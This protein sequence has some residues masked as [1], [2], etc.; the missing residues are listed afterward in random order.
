MIRNIL[1]L[2]LLLVISLKIT[3]QGIE[4]FEGTWDQVLQKAKAENKPIFVDAY[5]KWCG[6]CKAMSKTVFPDQEVGKFF[7]KNFISVK[8]DMEEDMG[9]AF[10]KV[11]PV[12][13][14]P[15]L[16]FI[17]QDGKLLKRIVGARKAD[18]LIQEGKMVLLANDRSKNF[19]ADYAA[20][21]R[22]YDFMLQYVKA[23]ASSGKSATKVANEY[24]AS[25]PKISKEQ[26]LRFLFEAS[27]DADSKIFEEMV[28]QKNEILKM[29]ST[30]EFDERVIKS[31]ENT[32]SKA[33]EFET[34]SL[35]NEAIGKA[36]N[37]SNN[38]LVTVFEYQSKVKYFGALKYKDKFNEALKNHIKKTNKK[39]IAALKSIVEDANNY[40]PADPLI[41]KTIADVTKT[42]YNNDKSLENLFLYCNTLSKAGDL[43]KAVKEAENA[44]KEAAKKGEPTNMYDKMIEVIKG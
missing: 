40:F 12:S 32:V 1:V 14:Y 5:A 26:R 9:R 11:F 13:A 34:E 27:T 6:P 28:S 41:S 19:E 44:K 23:L 21:K 7:N 8:Y 22:D 10:G 33:L 31:C 43:K 15:T 29:Y 16:F 2:S 18:Q 37:A 17:D 24:L 36:S 38:K 42:I 3:A 35:L 25:N 30:E 20:G 4:F 39:D